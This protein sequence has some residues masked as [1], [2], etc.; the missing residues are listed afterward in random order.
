MAKGVNQKLKL[1]YL[2]KIFLEKTDEFH[3]ITMSEII[4]ELDAYGVSAERKSIYDDIDTLCRY[5]LDIVG[6]KKDKKYMYHVVSRQFELAELKLLVDS[7]Q[8][9]KFITAKKSNELI[10]KIEGLAS[11]HE[12]KQLQRQVYVQERI[13]TN[14]EN[15][16]YNVDVIHSAIAENVKITFQYFQWNVKKEMELRH[17]G[18][19]YCISPWALS[20]DDENYYL[21]GY[22]SDAAMIKHYRVDKMLKIDVT[23]QPREGRAHFE[24]FDMA[25]YAKKVFGMFD[26]EEQR[27][28]LELENQFAGVIIDRFGTSVTMIKSDENHFTVN[29]DVAVSR[30]FL[31]WVMALGDGVKILSPESVVEQMKQEIRSLNRRY[32]I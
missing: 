6:E 10:K 3:C 32:D 9:A 17:D 11:N 5:G 7:V 1:L 21:V 2:M 31:A 15:I 19:F 29:V 8:A 24:K 26:G 14:N 12:A 28:K 18:A 16:F 22:D 13:K 30:Q 25:V 20:W 23:D 4:A 27:V